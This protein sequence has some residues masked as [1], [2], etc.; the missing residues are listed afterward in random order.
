MSNFTEVLNKFGLR[1]EEIEH[2]I[3][4]VFNI[5]IEVDIDS[6]MSELGDCALLI[7]DSNKR[8]KKNNSYNTISNIYYI[9]TY[10]NRRELNKY[11][12]EVKQLGVVPVIFKNR[13]SFEQQDTIGTIY[14]K[15][16]LGKFQS[17]RYSYPS[18]CVVY[19]TEEDISE[20]W[21]E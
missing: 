13:V 19:N 11:K 2:N 16:E 7:K 3:Y 20:A 8:V 1:T 9:T 12:E 10:N 18:L 17:F 15:E 21:D 4:K 5:N 14:S 6:L